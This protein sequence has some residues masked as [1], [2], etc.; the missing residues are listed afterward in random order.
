MVQKNSLKP[1]LLIAGSTAVGKS[2]FALELC[3]KLNMEIISADSAQ[4]Y[5]ALKVGTSKPSKQERALCTHHLVDIREHTETFNAF[6]FVELARPT[7]DEI[8]ERGKLPV[9]VG[10]T[11]LYIESLLF[12]FDFENTRRA[13]SVY[14]FSL[15]IL[16]QPREI[17]YQKINLR[18]D[19]MIA[20]GLVEE[21]KSLKKQGLTLDNQCM[22]AIGY[23]QILAHLDGNVS[24]EDAIDKVKQ[25]TRNYAKRQLT[26][27]RHMTDA[28][29]VDVGEDWDK[30]QAD[31]LKKYEKFKKNR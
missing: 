25:A 31:I 18:V 10:G 24:L 17:L 28:V 4:V 30:A 16:N 5:R 19:K 8:L 29:W 27:F 1:L 23:K 9:V 20:D 15:Y 26:W 21:V 7:I 3:E 22:H 11:G 14:D 12:D 6:D 13:N 2:K